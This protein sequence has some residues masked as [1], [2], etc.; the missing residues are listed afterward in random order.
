MV[1]PSGLEVGRGVGAA[2]CTSRG[3]VMRLVL[4]GLEHLETGTSS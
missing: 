4:G 1:Q 3:G 2:A